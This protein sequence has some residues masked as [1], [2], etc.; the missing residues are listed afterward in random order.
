[1][2]LCRQGEFVPDFFGAE[3]AVE[4]ECAALSRTLEYVEFFEEAV[5]VA[6]YEVCFVYHVAC[7]YGVGTESEVAYCYASGFFGVVAVV[8][9]SVE[10]CLSAYY[11]Y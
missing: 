1:M 3:G 7:E 2:F 6:G 9:L 11:F 5:Y 4:E 8:A 10:F